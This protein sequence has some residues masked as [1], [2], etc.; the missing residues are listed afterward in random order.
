MPQAVAACDKALAIDPTM[1]QAYIERG[2]AF[3]RQAKSPEAIKDYG[4]ALSLEGERADLHMLIGYAMM[5]DFDLPG[6]VDQAVLHYSKALELEPDKAEYHVQVGAAYR[7]SGEYAKAEKSWARSLEIKQALARKRGLDLRK[8]RLIGQSWLAAIGHLAQLDTHI[9]MGLLGWRRED[10]TVLPLDPAFHISNQFL[11]DQWRPF[12]EFAPGLAA[13]GLSKEDAY[14]LEDEY[15]VTA[16]P[17]GRTRW[18]ASAAATIQNE[19]EAQKRS[20]LLRMSEVDAA[21]GKAG[22]AKLGLPADAWFVCLHVRESGFWKHLDTVRPSIRDCDV[23]AYL[24][25]IRAITARGGWV[26]RLGDPSMKPLPPMERV[27]DYAHSD[28][29]ADWMDVFLSA[30][31]RFFLATPSGLGFVPSIFGVPCAWTNWP[32]IAVPPWYGNCLWIPKLFWNEKEGR[33]ATV[34]E[35]FRDGLAAAEYRR[36]FEAKGLSVSD[37]TPEEILGLALEMLERTEGG[38]A[39]SE[40]DE[41]SQR[42]FRRVVEA[43]GGY[44]AGRV[45][46]DFLRRHSRLLDAALSSSGV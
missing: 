38:A 31:C 33:H 40:E 2:H 28:L 10:K 22:L 34:P 12:I 42:D 4:R 32:M 26:I 11:L 35:L 19:W 14:L 3:A 44:S 21:R 9:K 46:R 45:G 1:T 41:L 6:R 37:N 43:H 15:F 13:L 16:F 17:D 36:Q 20:P 7:Q 25:A 39:Y 27:V 8:I 5:S 23:A 24:P 18:F 29:R 30:S